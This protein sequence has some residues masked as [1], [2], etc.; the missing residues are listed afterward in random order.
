MFIVR[1]TDSPALDISQIR[2]SGIVHKQRVDPAD[3]LAC[4]FCVTFEQRSKA[5]LSVM[6]DTLRAG[7]VLNW[8]FAET[9]KM[10]FVLLFPDRYFPAERIPDGAIDVQVLMAGTSDDDVITVLEAAIGRLIQ[11]LV[12]VHLELEPGA[13]NVTAYIS[14]NGFDDHVT[15]PWTDAEQFFDRAP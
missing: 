14:A 11:P 15:L 1:R 12:T 4:F 9:G 3:R 13:D 6:K 8:A 2:L 5:G 7:L 10:E